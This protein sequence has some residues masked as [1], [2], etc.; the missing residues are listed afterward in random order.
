[1]STDTSNSPIEQQQAVFDDFWLR[2]SRQIKA[3]NGQVDF[4]SQAEMKPTH[5]TTVVR[6]PVEITDECSHLV[7]EIKATYPD[8]YYY[9]QSDMH[10]TLLNL[11]KLIATSNNRI[12]TELITN[13]I[14]QALADLPPLEMKVCGLGLFPTTIF[15]KLFDVSGVIE[16]YRSAIKDAVLNALSIS[17]TDTKALVEGIAFVNLVRFKYA[18]EPELVNMVNVMG[19]TELGT[20]KASCIELVETN[21][22]LS[23]PET[24]IR[25]K[26]ALEN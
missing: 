17:E 9:P 8:H 1:M 10:F 7:E 4:P 20:F 3:G 6:L 12:D 2:F 11:D 23:L 5:T 19:D 22:L 24:I 21:K 14:K 16:E 13:N 18:P 15:A 25:G 26:I